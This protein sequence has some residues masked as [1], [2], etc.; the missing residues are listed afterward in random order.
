VSESVSGMMAVVD[1]KRERGLNAGYQ[2]CSPNAILCP[3]AHQALFFG[4]LFIV[5]VL[6]DPFPCNIPIPLFMS[7]QC[8][9]L[10]ILTANF[11][12]PCIAVG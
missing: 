3:G 10:I 6:F 2:A 5:F 8:Q 12:H 1:A 4:F 9:H 7:P 11:D